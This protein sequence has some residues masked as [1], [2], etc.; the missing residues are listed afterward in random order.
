MRPTFRTLLPLVAL[1]AAAEPLHAATPLSLVNVSAPAIN[2]V[3]NTSCTVTVNDVSSPIW[4]QGFLQSRTYQAAPG[5]PA[6]GMWVYQYRVDLTRVVG[7]TAI[8]MVNSFAIDFGPVVNSV[9]FNGDGSGDQVFVVTGGGLGSVAPV[10]AEQTGRVITFTFNPSVAGGGS[11]GTGQTTFFFGLV[12]RTAPREMTGRLFTNTSG[13]VALEARAPSRLVIRPIPGPLPRPA[14]GP[15]APED[16]IAYDPKNL[17]I[18]DEGANG[19]V[20]MSGNMRMEMLD[21]QTDAG[22]A[23]SL[24]SQHTHQCFVGRNNPRPNRIDYIMQ[25]WRGVSGLPAAPISNEDCISY[26]S[27]SVGVFERGAIGWRMEAGSMWMQLFDN[28]ADANRGLMTAQ[29]FSKQCFIGR[30][31]SRPDRK[32]YIVE[33]WRN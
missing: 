17:Q 18:V 31:N 14:T 11:P 6:A 12:S 16:C 2:C 32:Q 27:A 29:A 20:L 33:Y 22:K 3:F 10:S 9:D 30:N 21:N 26:P 28:E 13:T 23:M 5:S 4:G 15:R 25:Y 1:A 8:P 19:F 24:A 7:T